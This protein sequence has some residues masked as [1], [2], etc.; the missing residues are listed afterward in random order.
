M[1]LVTRA[2]NILLSPATEWRVIR[3]ETETPKTLLVKYVIPMALIPAIARFI[4]FGLIGVD[5]F[6]V[7]VGGIKWGLIWAIDSFLSSLVIYYICTYVIDALAP[8]FNSPKN[9]GRSAQIVAYSYTAAWVAG[10]FH[11]LP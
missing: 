6:V 9:I 3:S 11:I 2:K 4:G 8:N 1:S 7:H 5:A 10:I